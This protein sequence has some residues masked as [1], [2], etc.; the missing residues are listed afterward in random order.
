MRVNNTMHL[1]TGFLAVSVGKCPMAIALERA[2]LKDACKEGKS[3][4][5][6]QDLH[7]QQI[8]NGFVRWEMRSV[9]DYCNK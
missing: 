3:G 6:C 9:G 5:C 2:N 8:L 7:E 1:H 4:T